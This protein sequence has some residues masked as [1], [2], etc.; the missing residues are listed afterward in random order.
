M[1]A[2]HLPLVGSDLPPANLLSLS[3]SWVFV[4]LFFCVETG[5]FCLLGLLHPAVLF[6]NALL[7]P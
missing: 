4:F 6:G 5:P 3:P 7:Q 1:V 2:M